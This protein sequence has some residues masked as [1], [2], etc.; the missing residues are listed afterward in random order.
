MSIESRNKMKVNDNQINQII[1]DI[2]FYNSISELKKSYVSVWLYDFSKQKFHHSIILHKDNKENLDLTLKMY[3]SPLHIVNY[4][5]ITSVLFKIVRLYP[6]DIILSFLATNIHHGY[7]HS[8]QTRVVRA[9]NLEDGLNIFLPSIK[10]SNYLIEF[11]FAQEKI[12]TADI[13]NHVKLLAMAFEKMES[14][15]L[16]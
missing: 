16:K 9:K 1:E 7:G 6:E 12:H 14:R 13:T 3:F 2:G 8:E 5:S 15:A 4:Q 10:S 11:D